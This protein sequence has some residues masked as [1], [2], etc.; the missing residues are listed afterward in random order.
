MSAPA[1]PKESRVAPSNLEKLSE[2]E[3]A[4]VDGF[5]EFLLQTRERREA[6]ERFEVAR[7][8]W[9]RRTSDVQGEEIEALLDD[10]VAA[11]RAAG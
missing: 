6:R 8:E 9:S 4:L 7:I 2:D 11:V 10:A 3:L 1:D 5:A